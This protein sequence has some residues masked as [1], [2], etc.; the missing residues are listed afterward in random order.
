[1][2]KAQLSSTRQFNFGFKCGLALNMI[3]K[4]FSCDLNDSGFTINNQFLD[5]TFRLARNSESEHL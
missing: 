5:M 1:M 3:S 2:S 4:G